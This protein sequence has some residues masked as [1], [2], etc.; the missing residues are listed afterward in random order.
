MADT[1][2]MADTEAVGAAT[3]V[4]DSAGDSAADVAGDLAAEEI[5]L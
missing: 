5:G 1:A 4:A 2:D 3:V